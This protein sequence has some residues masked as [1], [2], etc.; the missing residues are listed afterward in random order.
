MNFFAY[1]LETGPGTKNYMIIKHLSYSFFPSTCVAANLIKHFEREK[2][3]FNLYAFLLVS[4]LI[5]EYMS[6]KFYLL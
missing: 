6:R 2:N 4:K 1:V 5:D 3:C